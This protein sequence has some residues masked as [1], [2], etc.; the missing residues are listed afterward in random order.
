MSDTLDG[1]DPWPDWDVGD[2][3]GIRAENDDLWV[4]VELFER[5]V[6]ER[7][8]VLRDPAS[9]KLI[10]PPMALEVALRNYECGRMRRLPSNAK[11]DRDVHDLPPDTTDK[12]WLLRMAI[13]RAFDDDQRLASAQRPAKYSKSAR[14]L[15]VLVADVLKQRPD[16]ALL[17][18]EPSHGAVRKWLQQ[19]GSPGCRQAAEMVDRSGQGKRKENPRREKILQAV[20]RWYWSLDTRTKDDAYA[21]ICTMFARLKK[22]HPTAS[23]IPRPGK[24]AVRKAIDALECFDTVKSKW[25]ENKAV[26][27]YGSVGEGLIASRFLEKVVFDH[28]KADTWV[29][30]DRRRGWIRG[31]AWLTLAIDVF[32]RVILAWFITYRRPSSHTAATLLKRLIRPKGWVRDRYPH[33]QGEVNFYGKPGKII[34]DHEWSHEGPSFIDAA[35]DTQMGVS[36]PQRRNPQAKA[37]GEAIFRIMNDMVF[38]RE[39]GA[40][41]LPAH[42]MRALGYDPSKDKLIEFDVLEEH[43]VTAIYDLYHRE[44]HSGIGMAP[45][46]AWRLECAKYAIPTHDNLEVLEDAFGIVVRDLVLSKEGVTH[47]G[48]RYHDQALVAGLLSELASDTPKRRRRKHGSATAPIPKSKLEPENIDHIR[49]W[50]RKRYRYVELPAAPEYKEYARDLPQD[51][52]KQIQAYAKAHGL[53]FKDENERWQARDQ[54]RR[55][56]EDAVPE[57]LV[58]ARLKQLRLL[59]TLAEP[60]A[61]LDGDEVKIVRV[62][63]TPDGRAV[64]IPVDGSRARADRGVPP[65]M[66]RRGGRKATRKAAATKAKKKAEAAAADRKAARGEAH[67]PPDTRP[68]PLLNYVPPVDDAPDDPAAFLAS[69]KHRRPTAASPQSPSADDDPE[70]FLNSLVRR[71]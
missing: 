5:R 51:V 59:Q 16:L 65:K 22:D 54:F 25:G 11:S 58:E 20:A 30:F 46:R 45:A 52:H 71:R 4:V 48:I 1:T 61:V 33:L 63:A 60:K 12:F 31:R 23:R 67:L 64:T 66:P 21:R 42:E 47:D 34:V 38:H 57:R 32:T 10:L 15:G 6:E 37:I 19:R 68:R 49:V 14:K 24:G 7:L 18:W 53:D 36:W 27:L 2:M 35:R 28:T 17:G 26:E 62:P 29:I 9:G 69:L 44:I 50:N 39:A 55:L 43:L 41:P 3:F 40:V 70:A 8:I 13:T 56:I